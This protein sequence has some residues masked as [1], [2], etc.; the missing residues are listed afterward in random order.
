MPVLQPLSKQGN[1]IVVS[2]ASTSTNPRVLAPLTASKSAAPKPKVTTTPTPTKTPLQ[3]TQA[4]LNTP[5]KKP[6]STKLANGIK[7]NLV[8][9]TTKV[10]SAKMKITKKS[11]DEGAKALAQQEKVI[12]AISSFANKNFPTTT[13]S[14]THLFDADMNINKAWDDVVKSFKE[15]LE[16]EK[17]RIIKLFEVSKT[18]KKP[19]DITGGI[20]GLGRSDIAG[21][22]LKVL[23]GGANVLF[24]PITALFKGAEHIPVLSA[25]SRAISIPFSLAGETASGLSGKLIDVLP[26]DK[27]TKGNI[28][29]GVQEIS[30]LAAQLLLGKAGG[31]KKGSEI[32]VGEI[33]D[34]STAKRT[35][36]I[37]KYG[38]QDALTIEQKAKE[39]AKAKQ[40]E[41]RTGEVYTPD[42]IIQRVIDS[43]LENT[44][45]GKALLKTAMEAKSSGKSIEIAE[46]P[47]VET[48]GKPTTVFRGAKV[49]TI[50][51]S[52][53]NGITGG[54][55][56]TV[57][58]GVAE[59]FAKSEGGTVKAYTISPDARVINHSVLE[60]MP[61]REVAD[62]LREYK[63]D[64]IKF[65]VPKGAIGEA[66]LR[67]IN[68][69]VLRAFSETPEPKTPSKIGQSIERKAIEDNLTKGFEGVAGYDKITIADQARR[70]SD[71]VNKDFELARKVVRGEE[72]LPA[73]LRGTA[74]ITAMEQRI[75][76]TGDA[77]LAYELA[78][79]PLV[80]RT[81][82]AAQ[83]LRLAAERQPDS[84]AL[85]LRELRQIREDAVKK[86]TGQDVDTAIKKEVGKIKEETK[87]T[88]PKRED[89][90]SFIDSIQC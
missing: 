68:N 10:E 71:L 5:A 75:K 78:N 45:E 56:F 83:E 46:P 55:S 23:S 37:Q 54:V 80:S 63:I 60:G 57:E 74:L 53:P 31:G 3:I 43:P 7:L 51:T 15:P 48:L 59:R 79:S 33:G 85:K 40:K 25:V 20:L 70:A 90:S 65:D 36:L 32:K 77:E 11:L 73:N 16:E 13:E 29:E 62:F 2:S 58:K 4:K 89:W 19:E 47:P 72:P 42:E 49:E 14:F 81:S 12:G 82:A 69:R 67:V 9:P 44:P 18:A 34:I 30:A 88:I 64:V 50:D 8:D 52:R 1:K 41:V 86:R 66:E 22:K 6:T 28:K 39:L 38:L 21:A 76:K 27:T 84:L 17:K 24:S 26:I 35:E 61:K 87:K